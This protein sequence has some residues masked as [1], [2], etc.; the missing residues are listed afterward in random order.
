MSLSPGVFNIG[1]VLCPNALELKSEG[2]PTAT[3]GLV[4]RLNTQLIFSQNDTPPIGCP[5]F[6]PK[7]TPPTPS[8]TPPGRFLTQHRHRTRLTRAFLLANVSSATRRGFEPPLYAAYGYACPA[9][10]L[11]LVPGLAQENE[12]L[13]YSFSVDRHGQSYDTYDRSRGF[14]STSHQYDQ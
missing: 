4:P 7:G 1:G 13:P 3:Y 12:S 2:F 11:T 5:F 14:L 8:L 6:V 10:A 9:V